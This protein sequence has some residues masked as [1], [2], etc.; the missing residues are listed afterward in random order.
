[1]YK[2]LH[3]SLVIQRDLVQVQYVLCVIL[4]GYCGPPG[5]APVFPLRCHDTPLAGSVG[6]G[7][8]RGAGGTKRSAVCTD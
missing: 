3:C 4:G 7:F 2:S 6:W 8:L 1:M 5:L